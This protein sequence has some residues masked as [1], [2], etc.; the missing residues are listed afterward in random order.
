MIYFLDKEAAK[1]CLS[2]LYIFSVSLLLTP[3]FYLIILFSCYS[4]N[5]CWIF[6]PNLQSDCECICYEIWPSIVSFE[7]NF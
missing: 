4:K 6:G 2:C 5:V 7:V 3:F 1:V